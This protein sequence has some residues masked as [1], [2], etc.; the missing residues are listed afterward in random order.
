[1]KLWLFPIH[2][3]HL[4]TICLLQHVTD[5]AIPRHLDQIL[6]WCIGAGW[7]YLFGTPHQTIRWNQS[8][9]IFSSS[10]EQ[11]LF[12]PNPTK[13]QVYSVLT[14]LLPEFFSLMT[15]H[16]SDM[17]DIFDPSLTDYWLVVDDF[18]PILVDAVT[19]FDSVIFF[20]RVLAVLPT[21]RISKR[22]SDNNKRMWGHGYM[23]I[24]IN[25]SA[26]KAVSPVLLRHFKQRSL[27]M[28]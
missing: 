25:T 16:V 24:W 9:N 8:C 17:D 11:Q 10:P 15:V 2:L 28:L 21:R 13:K 1:M 4:L 18:D 3:V 22:V 26:T 27:D 20:F 6:K 23:A 5:V 19:G 14:C 12:K 7:C